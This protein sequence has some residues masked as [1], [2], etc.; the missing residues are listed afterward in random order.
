M[1]HTSG[2]R[3]NDVPGLDFHTAV[4]FHI[5]AVTQEAEQRAFVNAAEEGAAYLTYKLAGVIST[6]RR[7]FVESK[8]FHLVET[9]K[10]IL[11]STL[12]S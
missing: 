1:T 6:I 2:V 4:G 11:V 9:P 5:V 8:Y 7:L 12:A 3:R 10:S